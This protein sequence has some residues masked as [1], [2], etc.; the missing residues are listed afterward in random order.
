MLAGLLL[1]EPRVLLHNLPAVRRGL[2]ALPRPRGDAVHGVL[3]RALFACQFNTVQRVQ[4]QRRLVHS[5]C[6]CVG[7][8]GVQCGLHTRV[9]H[10]VCAVLDV[11]L[12]HL[13]DP[14]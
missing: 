5:L 13:H 3:P 9:A 10:A 12:H 11:E 7:V 8:H 1:F 14:V 6:E 4:C 2:F